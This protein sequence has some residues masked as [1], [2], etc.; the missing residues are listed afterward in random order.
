MRTMRKIANKE[1]MTPILDDLLNDGRLA[2]LFSKDL[3]HCALQLWILQIRSEQSTENRVV[4]GRLLPY[5]YSNNRWSSSDD[6]NFRLFGQIQAQLL[7]LNL[8]VESVHCAELLRQLSAG[9]TITATSEELKLELSNQLKQRIG[10]TALVAHRLVY[11]PVAYLL[12]RDA[13]DQRSPSS[14]HGGAG[15]LSASITRTDKE[16]LFRLDQ[17]YDVALTD[18]TVKQLNAETGLDFGGADAARF[19]DL[20]LMV[21]PALDD[22]E[23]PLLS[24]GWIDTPRALVARFNPMQVPYFIGFQFGLSIANGDQIA[25]SSIAIAKRDAEGVFECKFELSEQLRART[26]S[27]ELEI[28]GFDDD[29][30]AKALSVAGGG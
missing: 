28:F 13:F 6:D 26:D 10:A 9:R 11:R 29:I 1:L 14:P 19:G 20:E 17:D 3:H 5:S 27:T 23:R 30:P 21:F 25:Y 16:A 18:A 7:R 2:R 15:A 4:Y 24:V 12:N 8:Y 22:W